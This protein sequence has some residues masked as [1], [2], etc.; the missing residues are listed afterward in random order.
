MS[1]M[2]SVNVTPGSVQEPL[3]ANAH[4]AGG[5]SGSLNQSTGKYIFMIINNRIFEISFTWII[6]I[7]LI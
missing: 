2:N 4:T 6:I 3:L 5:T 1:M 7:Y